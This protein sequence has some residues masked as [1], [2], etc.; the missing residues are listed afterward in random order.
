MA[1]SILTHHRQEHL[2]IPPSVQGILI[3]SSLVLA[4]A[5]GFAT[6]LAFANI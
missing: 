2:G 1:P 4:L 5:L 6:A 3:A